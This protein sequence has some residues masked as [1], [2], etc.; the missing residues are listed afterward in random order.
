MP[1]DP[2]PIM[3]RAPTAPRDPLR[4]WDE[5]DL[6]RRLCRALETSGRAVAAL[7][8][9]GYS[10]P[11]DPAN[12]IKPEKVVSETA[13]LLL[14]ADAVK[15]HREVRERLE[16]V[17]RLIIPAARGERMR[18]GLLLYPALARDFA[19]AHGCLTRIGHPDPAFDR[20][21]AR[22]ISVGSAL[23]RERPPHRDLEQEW[24]RRVHA[25][26]AGIA[27]RDD[28]R[29]P[30]RSMLGR[31]LDALGSTRGDVYAL[32]HALMYATDLGTRRPRLPRP[33]ATII[34][35]AEAALAW[36]L[37]EQDYDLGGEVLLAWPM[38]GRRWSAPAAFGFL[39]LVRVED[40]A[41]FLPTPMTR[42]DR[43]LALTGDERTRYVLATAYHTVYVMGLLCAASLLPGSAPP[44]RI[45]GGRAP[46]GSG[47]ELLALL[48]DTGPARHWR[49]VFSDLDAREKEAV[50]PVLLTLAL[51]RAFTRRDLRALHATLQIGA[52][53][54][55]IDAPAP[56]QAAELLRRALLLD[57]GT[58]TV[59]QPPIDG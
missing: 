39:V 53:H 42:V 34:A 15:H 35:D 24:L 14:A 40:E 23:G 3:S 25:P 9:D 49:S 43:Y 10:D 11:A 21:A 58:T 47:G 33:I 36:A 28:P 48:D 37:D 44:D 27:P 4:T 57:G 20:L 19:F 12:A 41:G 1:V 45:P 54:D 46:R 31:A 13:M 16:A 17:A 7:S 56:R 30:A 29:L 38:M 59:A 26:E 6:I 32:T 51:R 50:A 55:L 52:R 5:T 22:S 8:A 2:R 18:A